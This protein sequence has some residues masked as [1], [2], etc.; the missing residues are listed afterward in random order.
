MAAWIASNLGMTVKPVIVT[1]ML[2]SFLEK[3]Q[4]EQIRLKAFELAAKAEPV[5]KPK[6]AK[7]CPP[8]GSAVQCP[9]ADGKGCQVNS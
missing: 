9:A 8:S 6:K 2:G 7:A 4:V 5:E 1:V 3:E